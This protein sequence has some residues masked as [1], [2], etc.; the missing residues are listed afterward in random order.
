MRF[1]LAIIMM[2]STACSASAMSA[3]VIV[4]DETCRNIVEVPASK[5]LRAWLKSLCDGKRVC[6]PGV[7]K[8]LPDFVDAV[9]GNNQNWRRIC[10]PEQ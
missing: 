3:R 10:S 2:L 1:A 6:K 8:D 7:P 4:I 5:E 9:S